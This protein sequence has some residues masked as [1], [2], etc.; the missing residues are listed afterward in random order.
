LDNLA[1]QEV[2]SD[3]VSGG[4]EVVICVPVESIPDVSEANTDGIDVKVSDTKITDVSTFLEF[5]IYFWLIN[6]VLK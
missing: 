4:S 6:N 2:E 1:S 3:E 5:F